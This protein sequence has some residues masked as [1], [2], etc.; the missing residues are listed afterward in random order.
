MELTARIHIE[1]GSYRDF[2]HL[3]KQV[4]HH[5]TDA[6]TGGRGGAARTR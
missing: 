6:P 5:L 4:R 3:I 1:E 2:R